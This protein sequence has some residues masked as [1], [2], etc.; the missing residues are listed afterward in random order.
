MVTAEHSK[1]FTVHAV[2][3]SI[4]VQQAPP[5]KDKGTLTD[6]VNSPQPIDNRLA[7]P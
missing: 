5:F 6:R 3:T 4:A 7:G 1:S 2:A